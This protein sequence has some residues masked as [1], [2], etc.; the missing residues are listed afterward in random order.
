MD[1]LTKE[2]IIAGLAQGA[3]IIDT[4]TPPN[5]NNAELALVRVTKAWFDAAQAGDR[6]KR[7]LIIAAVPAWA[8]SL[9]GK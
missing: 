3:T 8:D 6:G 5:R 1:T 2:L 7:A 9:R 4:V